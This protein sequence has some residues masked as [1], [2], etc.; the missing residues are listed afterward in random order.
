METSTHAVRAHR[1]MQQQIRD[2]DGEPTPPVIE[3]SA[4]LRQL[5]IGEYCEWCRANPEELWPDFSEFLLDW[6]QA[7]TYEDSLAAWEE[8][9]ADECR[10]EREMEAM[11][12]RETWPTCEDGEIP[13]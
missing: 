4:E 11:R 2:L 5:A 9:L 8:E 10:A 1:S 13:F 6:I 3:I 12:Q 7:R